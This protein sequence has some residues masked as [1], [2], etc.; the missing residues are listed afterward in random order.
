MDSRK[1]KHIIF[2]AF[3]FFVYFWPIGVLANRIEP[4]VMGLPFYFFWTWVL[5]PFIA[6]INMTLYAL[7]SAKKDK[8]NSDA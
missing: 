6:F 4:F 8:E 3:L 2:Q 7:Y 1:K 5:I